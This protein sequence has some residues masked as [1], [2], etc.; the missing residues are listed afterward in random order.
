MRRPSIVLPY[1]IAAC[2]LC[3]A[4]A[5]AQSSDAGPSRP[6]LRDALS[7]TARDAYD[8]AT[9][10]YDNRDFGHALEKYRQAYALAHDPRLLFDMAICSRDLKAYADMQRLLVEYQHEAAADLSPQD[11]AEIESAL[12]AIRELVAFISLSVSEAG[13]EVDLDGHDVGTSPL[14]APLVV[15]LGTHSLVV[16][17]EGFEVAERSLVATGGDTVNIAIA[18]VPRVRPGAIHVVGDTGDLIVVDGHEVGRQVFDGPLAPG[19]HEVHV[20]APGKKPFALHFTLSDGESRMLHIKL[21][22]QPHTLIWPWVTAGALAVAG[23]VVGGYFL[24]RSPDSR[25]GPQGQLFTTQVPA[26][27]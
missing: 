11:A 22:D 3:A 15:D 21:E 23:A 13:A 25:Q 24:F 9:I 10:L 19:D 2:V 8:S 7:G 5:G 4:S 26:G 17:K 6:S 12:A 27:Q 18:L 20:A 14:G 1:A 16:R